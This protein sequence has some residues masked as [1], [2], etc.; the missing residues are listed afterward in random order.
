MRRPVSSGGVE[1]ATAGRAGWRRTFLFILMRLRHERRLLSA[2][3]GDVIQCM[4]WWGCVSA[5]KGGGEAEEVPRAVSSNPRMSLPPSTD[6]TPTATS[7]STTHSRLPS[8]LAPRITFSL[9]LPVLIMA[10]ASPQPEA[11]TS[12]KPIESLPPATASSSKAKSTVKPKKKVISPG[13]VYISRIPP[14]MTPQKIKHLMS[15]WGE[16]GKV[17]A[18]KDGPSGGDPGSKSKSQS[19]P[20]RCG[21]SAEGSN[22]FVEDGRC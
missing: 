14:G 10:S 16:T 12:S 13:I 9:A 5:L 2:M 17:Y 20:S 18:Q 11:S 19:H 6:R 3:G 8:P 22:H 15:R 4:R 21:L 1:E 7:L